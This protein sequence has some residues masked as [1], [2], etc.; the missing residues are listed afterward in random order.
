M[1]GKIS[2]EASFVLQNSCR[3]MPISLLYFE[4]VLI[5]LV[6]ATSTRVSCTAVLPEL[7]ILFMSMYMVILKGMITG[8]LSILWFF[9][10]RWGIPLVHLFFGKWALVNSGT[11]TDSLFRLYRFG[12]SDTGFCFRAI[13]FQTKLIL[14]VI[15]HFF[16]SYIFNACW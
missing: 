9:V 11:R 16:I 2:F 4:T 1:N 8:V 12:K 3:R 15:V 5:K 7:K 13:A 6:D 14:W 10:T